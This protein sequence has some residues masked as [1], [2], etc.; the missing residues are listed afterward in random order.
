MNIKQINSKRYIEAARKGDGIDAEGAW[1]LINCIPI[2]DFL[3]R[4]KRLIK[5]AYFEYSIK[6]STRENYIR[7]FKRDFFPA[8]FKR[9]LKIIKTMERNAYEKGKY[10]RSKHCCAAALYLASRELNNLEPQTFFCKIFKIS[11]VTMGRYI[12]K[13]AEG[14]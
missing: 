10:L 2:Q 7:L 3:K 1:F 12:K 8:L 6:Y 14:I 13:H 9:A 5:K 11:C 4:N